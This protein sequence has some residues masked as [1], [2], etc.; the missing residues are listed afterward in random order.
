[1]LTGLLG[2]SEKTQD[3]SETAEAM[4]TEAA[5]L[6]CFDSVILDLSLQDD[7]V[8]DGSVE[9]STEGDDFVT[10]VD[11]S[12]GG[13]NN[14]SSNPWVYI[15]FEDSGATKVSIDDET[16]LESMD[17][18]MSLR[19]FM[20]RLNG[21]DSGPS[22]VSSTTLLEQSYEDLSAAPEGLTY[23]VDEFYTSDCTLINDSSG[24]PGSPQLSLGSWWEYPGCVKTTN[25]PHLIQLADG[26]I[27]KLR[28]EHYYGTGQDDCNTTNSPGSD[29]GQIVL[30]WR[31]LP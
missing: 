30:R 2:C 13:Y 9:T 18:D 24:L 12:A 26:R 17:W 3:T 1:M 10:L 4:C 7:A 25:Y 27:V 5:E 8:S 23:F 31:F 29:S 16:A 6:A 14:A 15:K 11:A 19:R 22:C 20:I 28:V 21:G